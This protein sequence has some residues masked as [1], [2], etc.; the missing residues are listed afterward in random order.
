[1]TGGAG[2][3]VFIWT[4][5]DKNEKGTNRDVDT[6][7]DF[8]TGNDKLPLSDLLKGENLKDT[9]SMQTYVSWHSGATLHIGST[10]RYTE[11]QY[12]GTQDE[13]IN[14]YII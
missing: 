3:D 10:R 1:M 2:D 11:G 7:T 4:S 13:W 9:T 5:Q 12:T 6:I 8:G 14:N